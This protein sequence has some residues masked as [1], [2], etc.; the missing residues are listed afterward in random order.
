MYIHTACLTCSVRL[1]CIQ[2]RLWYFNH[3]ITVFKCLIPIQT[4][5]YNENR[6]LFSFNNTSISIVFREIF[7]PSK[8]LYLICAARQIFANLI[9]LS[10]WKEGCS[11][12]PDGLALLWL[13]LV[14]QIQESYF[15]WQVPCRIGDNR[16]ELSWALSCF[17]PEDLHFRMV[18]E[19]MISF[20]T[21]FLLNA[22]S[23]DEWAPP[24][25]GS[26]GWFMKGGQFCSI[27]LRETEFEGETVP[28]GAPP[29]GSVVWMPLMSSGRGLLNCAL[30][31]LLY[32][33]AWRALECRAVLWASHCGFTLKCCFTLRT[34]S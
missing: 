15:K 11:F 5:S 22:F 3:F 26:L 16:E 28:A 20:P 24:L 12:F 32:L 27:L 19:R 17:Q 21:S 23:V 14:P 31:C 33:L 2:L 1:V 30:L 13:S 34:Q 7:S 29:E 25:Q 4:M 18:S 9:G 8:D 10:Q 6:K